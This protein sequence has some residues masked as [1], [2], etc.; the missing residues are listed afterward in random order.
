MNMRKLLVLI[1]FATHCFSQSVG[2]NVGKLRIKDLY[3]N[4]VVHK[5]FFPLFEGRLIEAAAMASSIGV[6]SV[7][8]FVNDAVAFK[9]NY[10]F[11]FYIVDHQSRAI[12]F[13]QQCAKS[14]VGFC[15]ES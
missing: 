5:A 6:T 7:K 15:H 4:T 12:F 13:M 3:L 9:A 8:P 1:L 10:P 11:P 14:E 2:Y